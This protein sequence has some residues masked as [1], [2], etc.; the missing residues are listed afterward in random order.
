MA[1]QSWAKSHLASSD[2]DR[3]GFWHWGGNAVEFEFMRYRPRRE[4]TSV[5]QTYDLVQVVA[6]SPAWG[7]A[8]VDAGIPV[9]LQVA[10]RACWER[11]SQFAAR[12]GARTSW[13][14]GMTSMT[15]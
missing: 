15:S 6:G 10:T 14:R 11:S 9:A 2:Q 13:R 4:L 8:V 12:P 1:P 5:L 7:A 3:P